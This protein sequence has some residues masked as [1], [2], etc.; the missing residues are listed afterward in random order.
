M[1]DCTGMQKI[2]GRI[3]RP[4][5]QNRPSRPPG[6]DPTSAV[7]AASPAPLRNRSL[8][9]RLASAGLMLF[10]AAPL[11]QARAQDAVLSRGDAVV[12]GFSGVKPSSVPLKPGTNPLDE[13][14]IDPNGP[15]AQILSLNVPGG[16]P[17]GQLISAPAKLQLKASQIGQVFATALDDGQGGKA[18]NIYLGATSAY[19]LNIVMP[20]ADGDGWP[21]RVKAGQPRAEWM[22]GQFA[23]DLGGGPGSIYKV[24]GQTGAVSLFATLL[25]N[26]GPGVGDIAFDKA[27]RQ[28]FASDL[29]RGLIYRLG[30]G[31]EIID[32]FDHGLAGR[33]AK[34]L[35]P[36]PDDGKHAEIGNAAFNSDNPESWGYTQEERR[37]H[38]LAVQDGRLFYAVGGQIWS[39]GVSAEGFA[40]DARWE[41]NVEGLPGEGPI[42]DMLFDKQGRL[43]LAQRGAQRAAYDYSLFAEP[44]KSAVARYV[45]EEPDNPATD[46]VWAAEPESY[47]I[48]LPPEHT[49]AEGGI[50]LGYSHDE[51]GAL[52]YGACGEM[53]WSTGHRLRQSAIAQGGE[54]EGEADVHGLQGNAVSLVQP[55][56]VPP[57]QS[58][59]GDYDGFF[60]DA[61]KAGHMGDVEIWQPCEGAPD[62]AGV[63]TFGELPPGIFPP[64]DV[65]PDL[66]PEY[67]PEYEF[68]TNLKLVK[69]A[70]PKTCLPWANGWLCRYKVRVTNT[71]PD[72]YFGPI[73]VDD[74]L[75]ANPP[76]AVMG[77]SWAGCGIIGPSS[78]RCPRFGVFLAPSGSIDLTAYAWV[79][80]I[81]GLCHLR[82][83]A[84]IKWAPGGSQW[85]SDPTD[86]EDDANALI[87]D[88]DC[89]PGEKTDLK[90]Y[91]RAMLPCFPIAGDKVRCGY[92]VTVENRG[93]GSYNGNIEV[94]DTIPAGTT[95]IFSGP[96]WACA[97]AAPT[98]TCAYAGASL[99]NVG[100]TVSFIV[101]IDM[102]RER[103]RQLNCKVPNEVEITEALG[104]T[105]Q[106]TDSTNDTATAVAD[107][108]DAV[109]LK[110]PTTNLRITKKASP[111]YCSRSGNDWWCSYAIRVWNMGPA[112]YEGPIEVEEAL[113]GEPADASWNAP[114]NCAGL[115]GGGGG[116]IC[117]HP[118]AIGLQPFAWR[119]LYLKVKFSGD[120]V[121][122]KNCL[123]PNVA[124]IT[125]AEPG[126]D[127]NTNPG[128]DIAADTAKVPAWFCKQPPPE[129]A[130]LELR[131]HGAQLQ[132]NI[133]NGKWRC[134][135]NVVVKNTGP[136]TYKGEIVVKDWLPAAAAGATMEVVAPWTC[137][138]NTPPT[139]TCTHPYVELAPQQQVV[140]LNFFYISPGN[141]QSCSL[142]NTARILKAP[143]GSVQNTNVG[144][145][146]ASASLNFPPLLANGKTYCYSPEPSTCPP[147]F[148]W[149]GESCDRIGITTPPPPIR[150]CPAGSAGKYPNCETDD[151]PDCP[152]GTVGEY[153]NCRTVD[154][155][156]PAGTVGTYPKC[157]DKPDGSTPECTDGRVRRGSVCGC[158]GSLVWNG[159]QCVRRKC[160]EGMRGTFPNCT[161]VIVDPPKCRKGTI[162]R[163]PNCEKIVKIC[164]AGTV[165]KYPNC[166]KIP[167][168]CPPGMTG[169]PPRCHPIVR[170]CPS[171]MAGRPPNCERKPLKL[172]QPQRFQK[173]QKPS[174]GQGLRG[175]P[176]GLRLR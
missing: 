24:D 169:K 165:G 67:P 76:G 41:L 144:D 154:P 100:D 139:V 22:A 36:V 116:A 147:G 37:V 3:V 66:P 93:P 125:K 105:P 176:S 114:W 7:I 124:K 46:S 103:A 164:P 71:G 17:S 115:G 48:G 137:G 53:L 20:D 136:G 45:R 156:C 123:L 138:D 97:V 143:G 19:G 11:S 44:E 87:P 149:G 146:Q 90:I 108:P 94:K 42:T 113:P 135:Y 142:L 92:R 89:K 35:A 101:R 163:W 79:P 91:K 119:S 111:T 32:S 161:K 28:F 13:F 104:G 74:W 5:A 174:F 157:R 134:P 145:D 171:G 64:G 117:T 26:S 112:K 30:N 106:N 49:S 80:K 160:P 23:I 141:Y 56:N 129:P 68:E 168:H 130:N 151:D 60:G 18:P 155:K 78:Y 47:A 118:N 99:P 166:R 83:V 126:T 12:T 173:F 55:E 31:G 54:G 65:P 152:P 40:K 85:N 153:P 88:P 10:L 82:N 51:T 70:D 96:G 73:V 162:G 81:N 2:C 33:P 69:R 107:V 16:A 62:F 86:D 172:Q 8:P 131:K 15:S 27:S 1:F 52:R 75:P 121:K 175:R 148:R 6:R 77:F 128:D 102:P 120:L 43:Y 25:D 72:N 98:S 38:G 29:D 9:R 133:E 63:Q 140:M 21:E 34:G 4:R 50:A 58:Y 122:E 57:Q 167:K 159:D 59:F 61:A 110:P 158:P 84:A 170:P 109:C 150:T 95:P 132:C 39:I 127:Q 14:F